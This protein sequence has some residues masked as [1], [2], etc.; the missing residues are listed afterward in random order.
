MHG[1][2]PGETPELT[3]DERRRLRTRGTAVAARARELLPEGFVVGSELVEG[4]DGIRATI[5][6]RPP[7]GT[8]VSAGF[9]LA[10]PDDEE[11]L[12]RQIAAGAAL[13]AMNNPTRHP[14]AGR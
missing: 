13:E 1:N 10:E 7:S 4:H 6:V 12:A 3:R 5:A 8:V 9:A 11:A 14:P 2:T